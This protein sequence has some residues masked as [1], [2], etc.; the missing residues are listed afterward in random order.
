MEKL[1]LWELGEDAEKLKVSLIN[2][3]NDKKKYKQA[4][5]NWIIS[6]LFDNVRC[7]DIASVLSK[8]FDKP[9]NTMLTAVNT[10]KQEVD[11]G[12]AASKLIK[13]DLDQTI[14]KK[15]KPMKQKEFKFWTEEEQDI[16]ADVIKKGIPHN[17]AVRHLHKIFDYRSKQSVN[18]K[19]SHMKSSG[20]QK[21]NPFFYSEE[22]IA[23]MKKALQTTETIESIARRISTDINKSYTAVLAKIHKISKDM[24]ERKRTR[25]SKVEPKLVKQKFNF[26]PESVVEQ[27]PADI[28]VDVP[29]GMT[30][31]GKPK[32]ISL[33][34]DHFRIYF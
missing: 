17:Q 20:L 18:I 31:E 16:I 23:S 19:L 15:S 2:I 22:T 7:E 4:I 27:Q 6:H 30:F 14:N 34:S 9:Y 29:H 25:F 8:V 10:R 13:L 11:K 3:E 32:R 33:H 24:P 26:Q 1:S 21:T 12:I 5:H 28:G